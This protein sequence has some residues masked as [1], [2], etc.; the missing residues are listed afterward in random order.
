MK[1]VFRSEVSRALLVLA[2]LVCAKGI[3]VIGW[4]P[5]AGAELLDTLSSRNLNKEAREEMTAGYYEGLINESSRVSG[6]NRLVTGSRRITFE[7]RSQPDRRE[8]HDF[9]FYEL[10]PNSEI[11]DYRDGR[12][13]YRLK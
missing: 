12:K 7:D 11:D 8:T 13:R 3:Q 6:M 1:A 4:S 5:D 10:I 2:V 9:R